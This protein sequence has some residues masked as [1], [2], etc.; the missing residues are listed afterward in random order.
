MLYVIHGGR[1]LK[2]EVEVS[3]AKN[4]ALKMIV[5]GLLVKGKSRIDNVNSIS[6]V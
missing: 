3:G 6:H 5:A 1:K 2:G 4:V